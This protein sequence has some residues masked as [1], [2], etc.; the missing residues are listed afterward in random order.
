MS[1]NAALKDVK[2]EIIGLKAAVDL[3]EYHAWE[4]GKL[5][6]HEKKAIKEV[7]DLLDD[8]E[9]RRNKLKAAIQKEAEKIIESAQE[10]GK[11]DQA[12]YTSNAD[13]SDEGEKWPLKNALSGS[14]GKGGGNDK[15]DAAT[16]QQLIN[17]FNHGERK[18]KG[19]GLVIDG[20]A[21]GK[22]G[23]A[24]VKFQNDTSCAGESE[25]GLVKPGSTTWDSLKSGGKVGSSGGGE[26]DKVDVLG[27]EDHAK[28]PAELAWGSRVA[29]YITLQTRVQTLGDWGVA[30][31][32]R[33][34]DRTSNTYLPNIE[35]SLNA[36]DYQDAIDWLDRAV[37]AINMV[38]NVYQKERKEFRDDVRDGLEAAQ[39]MGEGIKDALPSFLFDDSGDSGSLMEELNRTEVE[40]QSSLE[41]ASEYEREL[42]EEELE[43][44][45]VEMYEE[46]E[47]QKDQDQPEP[48]VDEAQLR[49]DVDKIMNLVQEFFVSG[50]DE[51]KIMAIVESYADTPD[52]RDA[53]FRALDNRAYWGGILGEK[54]RH[55]IAAVMRELEDAN[56]RRFVE[57]LRQCRDERLKNYEPQPELTFAESFWDDLTD[58]QIRD[59][60]FGYFKGMGE[61]G[62]AM[63]ES[64]VMLITDPV[65]FVRSIAKLPEAASVFWK[66]RSALWK[67]FLAAP[68]E[69]QARMIGRITGE[70]ELFLMSYGAGAGAT[71][72]RGAAA[73]APAEAIV[74]GTGQAALRGGGSS[75]LDLARMG[76]AAKMTG[77]AGAHTAQ[78][79]SI[80]KS[81][82]KLPDEF[83]DDAIKAVDD[84]KLKASGAHI[85]D[86]TNHRQS[87]TARKERGI[88]S[89]DGQSAHVS[90]QAAMRNVKDYNPKDA[91]TR[92]LDK[93]T[94]RGFDDY[95]K[96]EFR[97]LV[98]KGD[99]TITVKDYFDIMSD[100][101]KNN[102]HFTL[103]E[104]ASMIE[105]LR[106]E[107]YVQHGLRDGDLLRLPYS[108]G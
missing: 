61:A 91:L 76:Q 74:A 80:A 107:L 97:K 2:E 52:R 75:A 77:Q 39:D 55:G 105:L 21:G 5:E 57:L 88:S 1:L 47:H 78:T 106:D 49:K 46:I 7:Q 3:V 60:I 66:N 65:E 100:A 30:T 63:A 50:R 27:I 18:P 23:K 79:G 24:I 6:D 12:R 108:K 86:L 53:F 82:D 101:A 35:K 31:H 43:T 94:H 103:D 93:T 44:L 48:A 32:P 58:G 34:M 96:S 10:Q 90:A 15:H 71:P 42:L 81:T 8:A 17:L 28:D 102:I 51:A 67:K 92:L 11:K 4:D 70:A 14:V 36:G 22:T 40:L 59:Q 72:A 37:N 69:E 87:R 83:V 20:L 26:A 54:Y 33:T 64:V 104:A 62:I 68:P 29:D 16:V 56:G 41:N 73:L 95:W 25:M 13:A 38:W 45:Y 85:D 98:A 9:K 89:E 19:K 84:D 99:K